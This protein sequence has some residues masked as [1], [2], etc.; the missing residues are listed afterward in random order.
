MS[1]WPPPARFYRIGRGHNNNRSC[2][3]PFDGSSGLS[4]EA[5]S[6]NESEPTAMTPENSV[7]CFV[8]TRRDVLAAGNHV[9]GRT[10]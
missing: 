10:G 4:T 2:P 5:P 9:A 7:S 8:T 1:S 3:T 6:A